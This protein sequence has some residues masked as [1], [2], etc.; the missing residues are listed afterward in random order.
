MRIKYK[1]DSSGRCYTLC[2]HS[3]RPESIIGVITGIPYVNSYSCQ[4]ECDFFGGKL[5]NKSINCK[6]NKRENS[7]E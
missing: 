1:M 7:H 4:T 6:Y 5:A 3:H 2:P